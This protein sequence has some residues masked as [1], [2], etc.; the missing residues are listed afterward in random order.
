MGILF[1]GK[2]SLSNLSSE[3]ISSQ[4]L[5]HSGLDKSNHPIL[6][7]QSFSRALNVTWAFPFL[8]VNMAPYLFK[9]VNVGKVNGVATSHPGFY[10]NISDP[11]RLGLIFVVDLS[12]TYPPLA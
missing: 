2:A 9:A 4:C 10:K 7:A 1:Y 8:S 6:V 3:F 5:G 12:A 11:N